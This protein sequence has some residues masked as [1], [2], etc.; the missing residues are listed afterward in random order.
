MAAILLY[1]PDIPNPMA[2]GKLLPPLRPIEEVMPG[3]KRCST[4]GCACEE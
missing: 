1:T 3:S 4:K 2:D